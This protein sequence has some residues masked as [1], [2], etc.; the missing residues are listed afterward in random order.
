M[1]RGL[2]RQFRLLVKEQHE[3]KALHD[4]NGKRSS[5]NRVESLLH[6]IVRKLTRCGAWS[7]H[8]GVLPAGILFGAFASF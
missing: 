3:P 1:G 2:V 6:K 4:L 8:C 5:A 7:W